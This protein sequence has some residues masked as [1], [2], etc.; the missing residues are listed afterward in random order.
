[1][2]VSNCQLIGNVA[3]GGTAGSSA[4]GGDALGGGLFAGSGMVVLETVLVSGNQSQGG[5]DSGGNTTGQGLGG[6]VYANTD[7]SVTADM[8][9]LIAGNQASKSDNDVWGTITI[10]P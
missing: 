1:L 3:Q 10:R 6:G 8:E 9:T 7:A 5:A 2:I 4:V